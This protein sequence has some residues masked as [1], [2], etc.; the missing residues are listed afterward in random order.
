MEEDIVLIAVCV[1]KLLPQ[2]CI[3]RYD[4]LLVLL[5]CPKQQISA[6]QV[7]NGLIPGG[8]GQ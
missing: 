2:L 1:Q 6:R 5:Q 3:S 8:E 7:I 4:M